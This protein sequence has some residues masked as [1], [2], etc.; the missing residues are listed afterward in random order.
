MNVMEQWTQWQPLPN[1]ELKYEIESVC[2][3]PDGLFIVLLDSKSR[4][5]S[6]S[7]TFEG[8]IDFYIRVND[9]CAE[10]IKDELST[11]Y[12]SKFHIEWTFFKINN[13]HYVQE[14]FEQSCGISKYYP[15]VHYSFITPSSIL[16]VVSC[17]A[18]R[19]EIIS[20]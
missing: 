7:I 13:S 1:L 9:H 8:L 20:T 18:P 14:F 10:V 11:R 15:L 12:G 17:K 4:V 16:D 3:T 5:N 2:N 19:C 6:L